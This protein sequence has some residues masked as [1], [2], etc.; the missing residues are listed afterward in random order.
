VS[1]LRDGKLVEGCRRVIEVGDNGIAR[2]PDRG[3]SLAD[4]GVSKPV[5]IV[6]ALT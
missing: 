3:R 4:P 6:L 5:D 1:V 2:R